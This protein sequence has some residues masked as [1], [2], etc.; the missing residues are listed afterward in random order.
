MHTPNN[1]SSTRRAVVIGSGFGGLAAAIR[2]QVMGF[3]TT[4]LEKLDKPGGRAY[5]WEQ[6][7]FRFDAGPTVVT[8][9][10]CLEELFLHAGKSMDDYVTMKPVDPMYRLF[11][12][13]GTTFDYARDE[14]TLLRN[15]ESLAPHDVEGYTRFCK[16]SQKV[17]EKGYLDLGHVPFLKIKDMLAVAPDLVKLSA[18]RSVYSIVS[19]YIK[20][21]KLRQAF[22]FNSLLIGG[23]PFV[24]SAIYTLI[25]PLEKKWGAW[26]PVGGMHAL[27]SGLTKLFEDCGGTIRLNTPVDSIDTKGAVVQGVHVENGDYLPCDLVV[28][29]ADI[30]HTYAHLLRQEPAL[31]KKRRSI[32]KKR[33]SPSLFV[34]YFGTN[35][36]FDGILQHNVMF[37]P[38]YKELLKDIFDHGKLAEDFSLYLHAPS[39]TDSSLAPAGAQSFYALS[40]VPNQLKN[41]IDWK[42]EGPRYRDKIINYLERHYMPG[43]SSAI[44][45]SKIFTP[46]DFTS[47]LHAHGGSAFSLEPVLTQSAWFRTHNRDK[48]VRGLYFCGAGT[49]PGAG[50]PGVVA[51]GKATADVIAKDFGFTSFQEQSA[52]YARELKHAAL[53]AT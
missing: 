42:V 11:W 44:L 34:V 37:G 39:I 8:A 33:Y 40:P 31:A 45:T 1:H 9:P 29:N 20:S 51:S 16:Y 17:F 5:Q 53:S 19:D 49:H 43:L 41:Q 27:V 6:D 12:E 46:D 50:I 21:P 22:T 10:H 36:S 4:L 32:L 28:S 52:M 3:S 48:H 2:L 13:D 14:A 18:H 47:R 25:H 35:K 7:G 30:S 26:F 38:R 15:I 23:N 24:A